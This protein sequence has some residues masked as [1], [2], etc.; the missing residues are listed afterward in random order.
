VSGAPLRLLL[1]D[2]HPIFRDGLRSALADRPEV[3]VVAEASD[4]EEAVRVVGHTRVDV[5]LMDLNMPGVSGIEA[6]RTIA[7]LP[8]APAVLVLTMH[9]DDE[10][11]FAALRAGAAGYLL[12]G[13][14]R[15]DVV[16]AVVGVAHGQAVFGPGVARRVLA[17]FAQGP[18][19][20]PTQSPTASPFPELTAREREVLD[21]V[22]AGLGNPAIARRLFLSEKTVRNS[23]STILTKLQAVDR[24]EAI[25]RARAEGLGAPPR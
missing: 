12:K 10:S 16:R 2:D 20:R 3:E 7:A 23:V 6:T 15:D 5:V 1:V 4:G 19:T 8:D 17:V 21:L 25:A 9:E 24:G 22:A 13:A 18:P 14:H 11:V